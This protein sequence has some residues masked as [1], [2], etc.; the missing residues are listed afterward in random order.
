M[1]RPLCLGGY[2]LYDGS[3]NIAGWCKICQRRL[4][5]DA[6]ADGVLRIWN[7]LAPTRF[8]GS[9]LFFFLIFFGGDLAHSS[10]FSKFQ[11]LILPNGS[12]QF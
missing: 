12:S 6:Y 2:F 3:N 7:L 1:G 5:V 10:V 8:V 9:S 4:V 11:S